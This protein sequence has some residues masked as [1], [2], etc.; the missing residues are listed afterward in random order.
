[1]KIPCSLLNKDITTYTIL[2]V[3]QIPNEK[4]NASL[5]PD[6]NRYM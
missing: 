3:N 4:C 6:K 1:M 2:K 5:N